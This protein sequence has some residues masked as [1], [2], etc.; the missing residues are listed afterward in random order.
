LH[1]IRIDTFTGLA[2]SGGADSVALAYLCKN[3]APPETAEKLVAFVVDHGL[4]PGSDAEA[5]TVK[6]RLEDKIG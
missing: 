3:G 6:S 4:R 5:E 1:L 2:I